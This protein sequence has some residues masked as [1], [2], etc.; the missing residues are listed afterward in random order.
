[1]PREGASG[2]S[3]ALRL[4]QRECRGDHTPP[5][6]PRVIRCSRCFTRSQTR[7]G[8][9]FPEGRCSQM[10]TQKQAAAPVL[11]NGVTSSPAIYNVRFL[12]LFLP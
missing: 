7:L 5:A 6:T 4:G 8:T 11:S 3:Q 12:L 9:H 10:R 1:M 2:L